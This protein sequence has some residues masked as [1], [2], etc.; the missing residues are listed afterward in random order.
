MFYY[1]LFCLLSESRCLAMGLESLIFF[2]FFSEETYRRFIF[3]V[4]AVA[5]TTLKKSV[6]SRAC[7]QTLDPLFSPQQ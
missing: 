4:I 5:V 1:D 6:Q 2:F 7:S 3:I